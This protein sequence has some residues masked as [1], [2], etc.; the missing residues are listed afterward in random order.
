MNKVTLLVFLSAI[1]L[2]GCK[3]ENRINKNLEGTWTITELSLARGLITDFS[4]ETRTFQFSKYKKAYTRTMKGVYRV[5]Y[6]DASKKPVVDTFEYQL[7]DNI[8]EITKVQNKL[9]NGTYPNTSGLLK[10]RFLVSNSAS[11]MFTLT[12]MDSTGLYIRATK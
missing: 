3:K 10:R 12:R 6:T 11:S 2:Q 4:N 7:K 5:D 8:I 9:T 1:F